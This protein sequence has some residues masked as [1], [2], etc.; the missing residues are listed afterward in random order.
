MTTIQI[1]EELR[2]HLRNRK[3][4]GSD[5]Y[6]DIIWDLIEDTLELSEQTKKDIEEGLKDIEEGRVISMEDL[7]KELGM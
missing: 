2:D 5:T 3:V 7:K 1:S 6:E 4:S